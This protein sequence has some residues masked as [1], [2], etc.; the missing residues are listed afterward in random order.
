VGQRLG[1]AALPLAC[2]PAVAMGWHQW[3]LLVILLLAALCDGEH[4]GVGM[5]LW[6]FFDAFG[7]DLLSHPGV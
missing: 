4:V 3:K 1:G 2:R 5:N 6:S 7:R